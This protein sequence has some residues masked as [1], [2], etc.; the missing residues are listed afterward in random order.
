M[1]KVFVLTSR[2]IYPWWH[3]GMSSIYFLLENLTKRNIKLYLSFPIKDIEKNIKNIEHIKQLGIIVYPYN[4]D[5]KDTI[6]KLTKNIFQKEPF[7]IA[8]YWEKKYLNYLISLIGSIKP[9]IIQVHTPHMFK[10]A[11]EISKIYNIPVI[12]RQQDIVHKQIESFIKETNNILLKIIAK[13]QLK[14][15]LNYEKYIWNLA[16]RIAFITEQDYEYATVNFPYIANKCSCIL[17]G[18]NIK[19][20]LYCNSYEK[21]NAFVFMASDQMPNIISLK[22]FIKLWKEIFHQFKINYEFHVY[23]NVCKAFEKEK[24]KLMEYNIYLEG[25]I[26][27]KNQL[28]NVISEYLAFISPTIQG[29]GYRTKIYDVISFGMPVICT[30]FDYKAISSIFEKEKDIIVFNNA[31]EL[32]NIIE[33]ISYNKTELF[34]ISKNSYNKCKDKLNID[35][36]SSKFIANYNYLLSKRN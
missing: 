28:D 34:E 20:N 4:H 6:Y 24:I 16:N 11:Y 10:Y 7:K 25:F 18:I 17:D 8:K 2:I 35:I 36:Q 5:T 9:D 1:L 13:W 14:K 27:D 3:Y 23:G 21:K 33:N 30:E 26:D 32:K 19:K 31:I 15:T 22:W 29:S 12:L